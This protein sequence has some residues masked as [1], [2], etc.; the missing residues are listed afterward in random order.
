MKSITKKYLEIAVS[1]LFAGTLS[2]CNNTEQKMSEYLAQGKEYIQIGDYENARTAYQQAL[3]LDPKNIDALFESAEALLRLG[4]LQQASEY[5]LAV[6][7]TDSKQLMAHVKLGQ[8]YLLMGKISQAQ[9]LAQK[10]L[11]INKDSPDAL[12]L[13]G[14]ILAALSDRDGAAMKA[15]AALEK[16]PSHV[17][18][19]LLLASLQVK[20]G[21][22]D[23]AINFLHH[24][25]A[26]NSNDV[27]LRLMLT[28]LYVIRQMWNKA[29]E[30]LEMII[31]IDPK[32]LAHRKRLALFLIEHE[33]FDKAEKVLRQ[34]VIDLPSNQRAKLNLLDFLAEK[35]GPEIAEAELIPMLEDHPEDFI[36]KFGLVNLYFAQN[37]IEKA[38]QVLLEIIEMDSSGI[39]GLNANNKL[40]RLY[41]RAGRISEAA[42]LIES[43]IQ[44]DPNAIEPLLLRGELAMD[45]SRYQDAIKDFRDILADR[46]NDIKVLRWFARANKLAQR[47]IPAMG[48]LI[49]ILKLQPKDESARLELAEL[50]IKTDNVDRAIQQINTLLQLEPGNKRGL[51]ALFNIYQ[52]QQKWED[53]QQ[54]ASYLQTEMP[55]DATGFYLSGLAYLR[56]GKQR[57]AIASFSRALEIQP[58]AIEPLTQ[59]VNGYVQLKR[60]DQ[61]LVK[62]QEIIGRQPQHFVAFNLMGGLYFAASKFYK[63]VDAFKN[64]IVIKP[65]WE[66]PYRN[67][68]ILHLHQNNK[69]EAIQI[70]QEGI[71]RSMSTILVGDLVAIYHHEKLHEKAIALLEE[72]YKKHPQSAVALNYL[73]RYLTEQANNKMTLGKVAELAKPLSRI[74]HPDMLYTIAVLA[75]RQGDLDKAQELFLKVSEQ[76]PDKPQVHYYL[77]MVYHKQGDNKQAKSYLERAVAKNQH[78]NG[79]E[80]AKQT[81]E[82][83][84]ES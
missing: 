72:N 62:L 17:P 19:I 24:H 8:L 59:L 64:A 58:D 68:A 16:D 77:G 11:T 31:E 80:E 49:Q 13:S 61:A 37:Y 26:Q 53:A 50:L 32:P 78:F 39:H 63:A 35:R 84:V 33:Q 67:L 20:T 54:I 83:L 65:E 12:V 52:A 43:I 21:E 22:I 73:V 6:I 4:D 66:D 46:P 76:A 75:Y 30:S 3:A 82:D 5:Y 40:A 38:E 41:A 71:E 55:E 34:T 56:E 79:I 47:P 28:N 2:G 1:V 48:S 29:E 69:T 15:N 70:L 57:D 25:I 36:L 23:R 51:E 10:G 14:G 45:E 9:V 81:L 74:Q 42:G 7:E 60:N 44:A 18:A 27:A